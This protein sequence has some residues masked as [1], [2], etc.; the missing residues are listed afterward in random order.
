MRL[1]EIALHR[2]GAR[3]ADALIDHLV[4]A[5][6]GVTFDLDEVAARIGLEVRDH[7]VDA[8][9]DGL[10]Q[11]RRS[12]LE[13][14]LVFADHHFIDEPLRR[15]FDGIDL[16]LQSAATAL[17]AVLAAVWASFAQMPTWSAFASTCV[18]RACVLPRLFLG[19]FERLRKRLDARAD[20]VDLGSDELLGGARGG[21]A[22]DDRADCEHVDDSTDLHIVDLPS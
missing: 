11:R 16:A 18:M 21:G 19:G 9:L 1:V 5:R 2:L 20:R 17:L 3:F 13:L 10:G 6:I 4:A 15:G 8:L 14:T 7:L 12:E 22:D